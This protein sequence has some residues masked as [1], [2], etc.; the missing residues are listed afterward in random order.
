MRALI[1][2]FIFCAYGIFFLL[3]KDV[4]IFAN[5]NELYNICKKQKFI[6]GKYGNKS[7]YVDLVYFSEG[8]ENNFRLFIDNSNEEQ[9]LIL[10]NL[11]DNWE[12]NRLKINKRVTDF[13][14]YTN[15][16]AIVVIYKRSGDIYWKI[17]SIN[18]GKEIVGGFLTSEDVESS[19]LKE[20]Y[21][22]SYKKGVFVSLV[23]YDNLSNQNYQI[24]YLDAWGNHDLIIKK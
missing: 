12:N 10:W 6:N 17:Y 15:K 2:V 22:S 8:V 9:E 14:A 23:F 5:Q 20:V 4:E 16:W 24:Y 13:W 19:F 11:D 1:I 3:S 7:Q 18:D 21:F